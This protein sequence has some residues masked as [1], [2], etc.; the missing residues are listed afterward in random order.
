MIIRHIHL[1]TLLFP[2]MT[3]DLQRFMIKGLA[4]HIGLPKPEGIQMA[5]DFNSDGRQ[6]GM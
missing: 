1:L 6:H 5:G 4:D 3:P 2:D